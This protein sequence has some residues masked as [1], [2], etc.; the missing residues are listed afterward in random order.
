M[1]A[2][3]MEW[4]DLRFFLA[5]ARVGTVSE[6]AKALQVSRSTVV[7]RWEKLESQTKLELFYRSA[8]GVSLSAAGE[9]L[10]PVA[11]AMESQ[12]D[13]A[14]RVLAGHD[15]ALAGS[16]AVTVFD[17]GPQ[18]F[19]PAFASFAKAYPQIDLT[20]TTSNEPFRLERCEADIAVRAAISS[21]DE[22]LFGRKVGRFEFAVYGTAEQ[23]A[24]EDPPWVLPDESLRAERTWEFA[25]S[26]SRSF[27]VSVRMDRIESMVAASSSKDLTSVFS[28]RI[29]VKSPRNRSV[30]SAYSIR[31][32]F[33]VNEFSLRAITTPCTTSPC[34]H[35]TLVPARTV[36]AVRTRSSSTDTPATTGVFSASAAIAVTPSRPV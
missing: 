30:P 22:H 2:P 18:I 12:M 4:D 34:V 16:L 9:S 35:G 10:L 25:R 14:Q 27:R 36:V 17:M 20:V 1:V 8:D 11:E 23:V 5:L 3:E 32:P 28:P 7:R 21:P 13:T 31:A 19:A 6:A 29:T 26:Q 24:L 33:T 15:E